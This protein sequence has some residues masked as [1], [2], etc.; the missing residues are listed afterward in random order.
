MFKFCGASENGRWASYGMQL[1]NLPR[2]KDKVK[3]KDIEEFME[4]KVINPLDDPKMTVSAIRAMIIP[5]ANKQFFVADLA[6]IEFRV[7]LY[8][9]GYND[10]LGELDAGK[11]LYI[12]MAAKQYKVQ[13][14]TIAKGSEER[15]VGKVTLLAAQYGQGSVTFREGLAD[16][17]IYISEKEAVDHIKTYRLTYSKIADQW[18]K[19][20]HELMQHIGKEYRVKLSTGRYLNYGKLIRRKTFNQK[21]KKHTTQIFYN[22]GKRLKPLYGS[23]VWQHRVSAEARDII[24]MKINDL[25]RQ[26]QTLNMTVHDEVVM[27]V[28]K[29]ESLDNIVKIWENAGMKK[30]EKYFPGL[31]LESDCQFTHRYFK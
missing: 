11:D 20:D 8:L 24:L 28:D 22:N 29:K 27:T 18:R 2:P 17:G 12:E 16:I 10:K 31:P 6:Q 7:A 3:L 1:Q 26:G 13:E 5:K 25:H 4:S 14:S 21:F 9:A 19:Y 23:L 30:I 15:N